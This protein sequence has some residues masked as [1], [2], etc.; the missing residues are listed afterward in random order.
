MAM[1]I[2]KKRV[3][4]LP[5]WVA[6]SKKWL[7]HRWHN[8]TRLQR[9]LCA[10]VAVI[11]LLSAIIPTALHIIDTYRYRLDPA[12]LALIGK[13]NPNLAAKLIYD[14]KDEAWQFNKPAL[15]VADSTGA[16]TP[17]LKAQAGGGGKDD[18]SLYSANF[19]KDPTKGVTITDSQTEL[20]FTMTPEFESYDAQEIQDRLVYP[21]KNGAK[22]IYTAKSNGMKEDIILPKFIG[23]DLEF[24]YKLNLPS[25]LTAKILDDG[26][27]GIFSADPI[28]FGDVSTASDMDAEKLKSAREQGEK[29]HLLFAIPAPVIKQTGDG[30]MKAAA[31]FT[32]HDTTLKVV[33]SHMDTL[34]YPVSVDPSVVV[35]SSSDF[36]SGNTEDSIDYDT[37]Q[38]S[39]ST[40]TGGAITAGW[41]TTSSGSFTARI[42]GSSAV[43]NGY[44]YYLGGNTAGGLSSEVAYAPINSNGTLGAWA[45]TTALPANRIYSAAMS[46]NG[47][48]YVYGGLTSGTTALNTV[49]YA[50]IN[51]NGTLGSWTSASTNMATAACRFGGAVY[52]GY[53]YAAGGA[54]G[55]LSGT[56][57][58]A[59]ASMLN[60]IQYA[61]IL[62][63]G[64]VGT[65]TTSSN[66]FTNA[67]KDPGL[68]IYNGYA[69][70][71]SGT[72]D[73]ITTY[74]ETYIAKVGNTGAIGTWRTSAE[75]LPSNGKY[76][77]GFRAYNG[78][79]YM[80]G[81][82]NNGA[83]TNGSL[84]APILANGDIGAWTASANM[85]EGRW[86][87]GFV[88][89]K[90][91]AYMFGGSNVV[92]ALPTNETLYAKID[93]PG[94]NRSY[95]AGSTFTTTRRGSQTVAYNGYLYVMGGDAGS[96]PGTTIRRA[97]LNTDGTIGTFS[98]DTPL[99]TGLTYFSAV[100]HN[101]YM[102]VVGG[103]TSAFSSCTT[104]GNNVA[105]V[106]RSAISQSDGSLG[107]WNTDTAFTTARYGLS[108]VAYNGYLY[109]MGGLNG[110]TFQSD[111]QYHA[112][113]ASGAISG[114]WSTSSYTIS[115]ARA[116][117]GSAVNAGKLYIAGGCSAGALTCTS[118]QNDIQ[119][120]T[121]GT[122]GELTG[123]L[124][125]NS[126]SFTTARGMHGFVVNNGYVYVIGGWN[127]TTYYGT[128]QF[129]PINSDGSVGSWS[130]GAA[131]ATPRAGAGYA[132]AKGMLYIAG[133]HNGATYYSDTYYSAL[134]GGGSGV[135]SSWTTS[136]NTFTTTRFRHV[137]VITNGYLY[138]LGGVDSSGNQLAS[139][140]YALLGDDGSVG[141]WSSTTSIPVAK[142]NM[143]AIVYGS[144]LFLFGGDTAA[145][146]PSTVVY[147]A[148]LNPSTGAIGTW[149]TTTS[150]PSALASMSAVT[151]DGY[152]LLLGGINGTAKTDVIY[153]NI[154]SGGTVGSWSSTT[155]FTGA[156]SNAGAVV[157]GNY[158]YLLGGNDGSTY[159]KDVQYATLNGNGTIGS[160]NY[161]TDMNY[162]RAYITPTVLNGFLYIY[163][164]YDGT[165]TYNKV[166]YAPFNTSGAIGSWRTGT[167]HSNTRYGQQVAISNGYAYL[168][169]GFNGSSTYYNNVQYSALQSQARV[170]SYSKLFDLG[171]LYNL[172]GISYGGILPG[173]A[174]S[175]T[176]RKAG[177]DGVYGSML[178]A[179]NLSVGD[180]SCTAGDTRYIL[181]MATIDDATRATLPDENSARS[182]LTQITTSYSG[183]R[184]PTELRLA[185]GKFFDDETLQPLD[186]CG[187]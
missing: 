94:Q 156:R 145:S 42:S 84:Y 7:G 63:D 169:G 159:Y 102:Y 119:Y 106:Y 24:S 12:T 22:L 121:F 129:A 88:F 68:A 110:S 50:D 151:R 176:Y 36:L 56:C 59:S 95:T 43:Y 142:S 19:P 115:T 123:S 177:T 5:S 164:G 41:S 139:T 71:S 112:I 16:D 75:L 37:D 165:T 124:T 26:A 57:G 171:S 116:Y 17:A 46:H 14:T 105:T 80:I 167:A 173:G 143:G 52:N 135:N 54:T 51:S 132:T 137:S 76:R 160:W 67:R 97:T 6:R 127:G 62:A 64:D 29:T 146:T 87:I 107:A 101:G 182:Y 187:A 180:T 158:V 170:G 44:V 149:N 35:T 157:N 92:T 25:T 8:M 141:T 181:V 125:T 82:T 86:G 30:D 122:S 33:A 20:S 73:G 31:R 89:D 65:W 49:I 11:M 39:R 45:T 90:G 153:A 2:K 38:I 150:L 4:R 58:N 96:T 98:T 183:G 74:R 147:S 77:F 93:P 131:L 166:D 154:G 138:V 172:T 21:M 53:L 104:S 152:V 15:D 114:A 66:T 69:Y 3:F 108:A 18:T 162:A 113:G 148:A 186:T 134:N 32:L 70:V 9:I 100:A 10:S 103:C 28:L 27:V 109:V 91:Y 168:S 60:S 140:Y 144:Y 34:T 81:G 99:S 117:A 133:G 47:K 85:T 111:I 55:T 128:T 175:I 163:G 118:S 79:L 179:S 48:M 13:S 126:T 161:T 136:G 83:N 120:G 40:I 184:A 72:T 78:Y 185:H 178:R 61:P 155:A 174:N 23:N 1:R 130:T